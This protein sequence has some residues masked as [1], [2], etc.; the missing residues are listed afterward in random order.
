[1]KLSRS[2]T[3]CDTGLSVNSQFSL[4]DGKGT[5]NTERPS[6]TST[7]ASEI[8]GNM[9]DRFIHPTQQ[10]SFVQSYHTYQGHLK[11][12]LKSEHAWTLYHIYVL[13]FEKCQARIP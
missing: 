5:V 12:P 8:S 3:V 6:L 11:N 13:C 1:M 7:R 10:L 4:R 2:P 9:H